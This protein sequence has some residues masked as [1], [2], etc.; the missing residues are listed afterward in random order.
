MLTETLKPKRY[1]LT[2]HY[3]AEIDALYDERASS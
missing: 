2:R 1:V 3:K